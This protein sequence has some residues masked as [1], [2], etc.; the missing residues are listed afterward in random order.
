MAVVV[1]GDDDAQSSKKKRI[2]NSTTLS[3]LPEEL[4]REVL[5]RLNFIDLARSKTVSSLWASAAG[6]ISPIN[7]VPWLLIPPQK[8]PGGECNV[9]SRF[10]N[11]ID[12][13]IHTTKTL[14]D[15]IR[16]S[17]WI[18]SS[19]GNLIGL[20]E[21]L[22]PFIFNP[23]T[24]SRI[25]LPLFDDITRIFYNLVNEIEE[26]VTTAVIRDRVVSKAIITSDQNAVV[27]LHG[28]TNLQLAVCSL[29]GIDRSWT[30]LTN[31]GK[32]YHDV[33]SI[34]GKIFALGEFYSV[35]VWNSDGSKVTR[36]SPNSRP[37][38][39]IGRNLCAPRFYF[40]APLLIVR[41]VGEY[42]GEA[43]EVIEMEME[44]GEDC[45]YRTVG[46]EV[47]MMDEVKKKWVKKEDLGGNNRAVFLGEGHSVLVPATGGIAADCIY[48]SDDYWEKMDEDQKYGGHDIGVFNLRDGK[49]KKLDDGLS[50]I[51][52]KIEP[53][54]SWI[55]PSLW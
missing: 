49:V 9:S 7:F 21:N 12:G 45:G 10:Y 1:S 5:T 18:G 40:V 6:S 37:D 51:G 54:A 23:L 28:P 22:I 38:F 17:F 46:F 53:P 3:D 27:L 2:P 29:V 20:S 47:F 50:E 39:A 52:R 8:N 15:E 41:I 36:L 4:L 34:H 55:V 24:G 14:P 25:T 13:H 19:H 43:G 11:P 30:Q 42:V 31:Q 35:D 16:S 33:S 26:H 32:F 44:I 48:Y